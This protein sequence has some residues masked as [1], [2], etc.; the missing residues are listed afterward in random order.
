MV[1]RKRLYRYCWGNFPNLQRCVSI[2]FYLTNQVSYV[3][4]QGIQ[5]REQFPAEV[6]ERRKI[7][8]PFLKSARSRPFTDARMIRDKLVINTQGR[9]RDNW[10]YIQGHIRRH[11]IETPFPPQPHP[12]RPIQLMFNAKQSTLR[13]ETP[14]PI[15]QGDTTK[16]QLD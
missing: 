11:R 16:M 6:E 1:F 7:L 5:C 3:L 12:N 15:M 9:G 10:R 2:M 14:T 8:Y 13:N 4:G